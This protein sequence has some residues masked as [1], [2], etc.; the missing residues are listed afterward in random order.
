MAL[1]KNKSTS[2]FIARQVAAYMKNIAVLTVPELKSL[3]QRHHLNDQG[4]KGQLTTRISI[5]VRDEIAKGLGEVE[6]QGDDEVADEE[7]N[8]VSVASG[9]SETVGD[10]DDG[11]DDDSIESSSSSS[12]D[13]IE[14]EVTGLD[15]PL[16][17]QS[18]LSETSELAVQQDD[19]LQKTLQSL[20]G[21]SKF[22]PGQQ[23]AI[24]RCLTHQRS[25]LVAP[26]GSGKSL[27]YAL[28][29]AMKTGVTIV[30]SPLIS[31]IED[32]LRVLPPR[33][34][35]ATLSGSLTKAVTASILDD[36]LRGRIKLLFVSPEK[37]A[38]ASF[39]RLFRKSRDNAT[40]QTKRLFP[41]VSLFCVD[42]AHWYVHSLHTHTK[43][44]NSP[45]PA[46]RSGPTTFDHAT[47]G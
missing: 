36:V 34:P 45:I 2:G 18:T 13:S 5:W 44:S 27:C 37:L 4:K 22:R 28:P 47:F 16:W 10:D 39:R 19:Q 31:L 26:T 1:L 6:R 21:H 14:L 40:G 43:Q 32:Q 15:K 25:L 20:F 3:A 29:A 8:D 9:V 38:S 17:D 42:E 46:S 35:A 33:L 23:W 7:G 24:R 41:S 12:S 11:D 30:V